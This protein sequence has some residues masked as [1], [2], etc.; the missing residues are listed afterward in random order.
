MRPDRWIWRWTWRTRSVP[1]G[2]PGAVPW[3]TYGN[4]GGDIS[5]GEPGGE[6]ITKP[7]GQPYSYK[8]LVKFGEGPQIP[9]DLLDYQLYLHDLASQ[10]AGEGYNQQQAEADAGLLQSLLAFETSD[11]EASLYAGF[12]EVAMI[13]QLALHNELDLLSPTVVLA[14]AQDAADHIQYGLENLPAPEL[15]QALDFIFEPTGDP[16][17]FALNFAITTTSPTQ[18]LYEAAAMNALNVA[19]DFGEADDAPL[20]TGP[21][22]GPFPEV[23]QYQL[24]YNVETHDLDLLT[25]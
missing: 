16:D 15:T 9:D 19:L 21:L 7:N 5:A 24:T 14:A 3:P 12:A 1:E 4:Y 8:Q 2:T 13:G 6:I 18:E 10:Q 25:V 17:V 11:P 20:Q 23:T 22:T